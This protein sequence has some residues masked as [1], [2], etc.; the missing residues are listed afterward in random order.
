[1]EYIVRMPIAGSISV[2]VDAESEEEAIE[3]AKATE[4]TNVVFESED[5]TL[6]LEE[7]DK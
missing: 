2:V 1:M 6:E 5:K 3:V 7:L 4:W